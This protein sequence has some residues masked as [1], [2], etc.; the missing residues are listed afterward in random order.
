MSS[1]AGIPTK[2]AVDRQSVTKIDK[3]LKIG[4]TLKRINVTC[5]VPFFLCVSANNV[6]LSVFNK[7][8]II[9]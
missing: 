8:R 4:L 6:T 1:G 2:R 9:I 3:K 7:E 5:E